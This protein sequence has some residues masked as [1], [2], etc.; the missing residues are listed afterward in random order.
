VPRAIL[1]I[2]Q[3]PAYRRVAFELGLRRC[4][5]TI[6]GNMG[7]DIQPTD[8][9]VI[10]NRYGHW[11][12][13]AKQYESQRARVIVCENGYLGRDWNGDFWYAMSR[14]NHNGAGQWPTG[15]PDRWDA[16]QTPIRPWRQSGDEIVILETRGIGPPG[17]REPHHWSQNQLGPV[18]RETKMHVRLR[19]HPGESGIGP[20]LESDLSRAAAVVT[21]GS[22]AA[23]KALLWGIPVFYGFP[24]WIGRRAATYLDPAKPPC[25]LPKSLP[26]RLP[27]FQSLAWAMWRVSEIES[28]APFIA[29]LSDRL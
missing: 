7:G 3:D 6:H 9:L 12:V 5:F 29:L 21:W 23:L 16:C 19:K 15:S 22:G 18:H 24:H 8:V 25:P 4:G 2:R 14:G 1:L 11:D 13:L 27:T 17:I 20:A 26:D 28:G 10:W